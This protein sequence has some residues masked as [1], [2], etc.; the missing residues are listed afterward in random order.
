MF[1]LQETDFSFFRVLRK[2]DAIKL[3]TESAVHMG[4]ME[5]VR[6]IATLKLILWCILIDYAA[7]RDSNRD[8]HI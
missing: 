4:N 8:W 2:T 3:Y 6:E 7:Q 1:P 5:I